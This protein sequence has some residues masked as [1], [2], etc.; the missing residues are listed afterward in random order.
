[1]KKNVIAA[2]LLSLC[3]L[4]LSAMAADASSDKMFSVGAFAS[5]VDTSIDSTPTFEPSGEGWGVRA[6]VGIPFAGAFIAGQAQKNE[7]EDG[8]VDLDLTDSRIGIGME[9]IDFGPATLDGRIEF[10][11]LLGEG[12]G[13]EDNDDGFGA[14]LGLDAGIG[15]LGVYGSAGYIELSDAHGPEVLVGVRGSL[16]PFFDLFGEYRH[17]ELKNIFGSGNTSDLDEF[18]VGVNVAF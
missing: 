9:F 5:T 11:H 3:A 17:N 7:L 2:T 4:P 6:R 12:G 10:V 1:M 15:I 18:R 14:H 8:G 13:G 16:L